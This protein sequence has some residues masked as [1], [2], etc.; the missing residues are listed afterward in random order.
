MSSNIIEPSAIFL[1]ALIF[2]ATAAAIGA[3]VIMRG[4][5]TRTSKLFFFNVTLS[6]LWFPLTDAVERL[7][8]PPDAY[9]AGLSS[10]PIWLHEFVTATWAVLAVSAG[11]LFLM[12]AFQISR[13]NNSFKP[14]PLRDAA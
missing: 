9:A 7:L 14:T 6:V 1:P 13:S 11:V 5:R 2:A 12:L 3:F 4:L 8:Y 10:P